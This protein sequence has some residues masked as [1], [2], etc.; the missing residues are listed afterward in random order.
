MHRPFTEDKNHM[1]HAFDNNNKAGANATLRDN[2]LLSPRRTSNG[3]KNQKQSSACPAR[4][5]CPASPAVGRPARQSPCEPPAIRPRRLK[6]AATEST[7]PVSHRWVPSQISEI[8]RKGGPGRVSLREHPTPCI[9]L[10]RGTKRLVSGR[11]SGLHP[12]HAGCPTIT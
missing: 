1:N 9:P 11:C 6:S 7:P 4:P 10:V 3:E 8:R 2:D 5:A 12:E